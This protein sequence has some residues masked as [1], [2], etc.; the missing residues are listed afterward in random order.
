MDSSPPGS[1]LLGILQARIL[2][3]GALSFSRASLRLRDRTQ[4][5]CIAVRTTRKSINSIADT[6]Y[7]HVF[8][9]YMHTCVLHRKGI[10]SHPNQY[11]TLL[12]GYHCYWECMMYYRWRCSR[13]VDWLCKVLLAIFVFLPLTPV[14]SSTL[15]FLLSKGALTLNLF[16][17]GNPLSQMG[18]CTSLSQL[19]NPVLFASDF[20]SDWL[21]MGVWNSSG[22]D[23]RTNLTGDFGERFLH[24][25]KWTHQ[26]RGPDFS[27]WVL[28]GLDV[29]PP[30]DLKLWKVAFHLPDEL[31]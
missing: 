28:A 19:G 3:W 7:I 17:Y 26:K 25:W 20:T 11:F 9:D 21:G 15:C 6:L 31:A 14:P 23:V 1:S 5:S 10:K 24:D 8:M 29:L 30:L 13:H 12:G 4:V 22:Q 2:E 18:S 27:P 16:I